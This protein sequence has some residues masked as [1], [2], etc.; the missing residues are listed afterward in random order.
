[1]VIIAG[2]AVTMRNSRNDIMN[3]CIA[4]GLKEILLKYR[5][6]RNKI[7]AYSASELASV[8]NVDEYVAI[9]IL[10]AAKSDYATNEVQV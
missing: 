10:N 8:L 5:F 2:L 1:V 7:L 4:D 3:M 9:L 6:T